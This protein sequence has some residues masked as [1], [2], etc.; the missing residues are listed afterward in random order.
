MATRPVGTVGA[1][2]MWKQINEMLVA[3]GRDP[4]TKSQTIYNATSKLRGKFDNNIPVKE[5]ADWIRNYM[6]NL[7]GVGSTASAATGSSS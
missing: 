1:Y 3:V 7:D 5:A 2:D 4:I 6:R